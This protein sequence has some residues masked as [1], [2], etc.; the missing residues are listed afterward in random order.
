MADRYKLV[1]NYKNGGKKLLELDYKDGRHRKAFT[2]TEIDMFTSNFKNSEELE[3]ALDLFFGGYKDG[4][5]TIEYKSSGT[6]KLAEII[7]SDMNFIKTLASKNRGKTMVSKNDI[8]DYMRYFLKRIETDSEFLNYISTRRYTNEYFRSALS[9]YLML[10]NSNEKD[11]QS[12]LWQAEVKLRKEFMRY[13]TIRGI[14]V[15]RRNYE[16]E[17]VRD[18]VSDVT[19]LSD[20]NRNGE[21]N[22]MKKVRRRIRKKDSINQLLLFNPDIYTEN[23]KEKTR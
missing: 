16:L 12:T 19:P 7:Y 3:K 20:M 6:I 5:F 22:H 15:G 18:M 9:N 8:N 4:F 10:K 13:K 23:N 2:L 1:Y 14:E 21:S 11:A 17:K